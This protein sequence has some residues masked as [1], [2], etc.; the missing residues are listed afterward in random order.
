M[1]RVLFLFTIFCLTVVATA[2]REIN[3]VRVLTTLE[4]LADPQTCA[5]LVVDMQNEIVSTQGG[6]VRGGRKGKPGNPAEHKVQKM[7]EKRILGTVGR[8]LIIAVRT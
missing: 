5:V 3:H 7:Q 2:E 8:S 4:E 1:Q 6:C